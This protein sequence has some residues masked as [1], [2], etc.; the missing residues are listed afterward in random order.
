[1]RKAKSK[2]LIKGERYVQF[3]DVREGE[4]F[5][6]LDPRVVVIVDPAGPRFKRR[7]DKAECV[8][9]GGCPVVEVGQIIPMPPE[10]LSM[11]EDLLCSGPASKP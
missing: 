2:G 3:Q 4:E 1:M 7:G 9:T 6:C 10:S 8:Y 11:C 5:V